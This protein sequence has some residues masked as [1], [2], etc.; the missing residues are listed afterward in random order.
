M[1]HG[2]CRVPVLRYTVFHVPLVPFQRP[3]HRQDITS[4]TL[5][6]VSVPFYVFCV[7]FFL[8][9]VQLVVSLASLLLSPVPPQSFH[10]TFFV[11]ITYSF[12][13]DL[14]Q[15]LTVFVPPCLLR[16]TQTSYRSTGCVLKI[17]MIMKRRDSWEDVYWKDLCLC[18]MTNKDFIIIDLSGLVWNERVNEKRFCLSYIRR[19]CFDSSHV[20]LPGSS[21]FTP[22][23]VPLT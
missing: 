6:L 18:L 23:Y 2:R 9:V 14:S 11:Q 3:D 8:L 17:E 4:T 19:S 22:L 7:W 10:S 1:M 5:R 12:Y 20:L 13:P 15:F 16:T 21:Y